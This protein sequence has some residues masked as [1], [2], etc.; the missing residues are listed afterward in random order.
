[1]GMY[2]LKSCGILLYQ[3]GADLALILSKTLK[4]LQKTSHSILNKPEL[5]V[6]T[7]SEQGVDVNNDKKEHAKDLEL[8]PV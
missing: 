4:L 5:P 3:R 8:Q 1:M 7:P 6:Y 2:K